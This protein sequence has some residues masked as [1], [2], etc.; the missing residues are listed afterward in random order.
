M[1]VSTNRLHAPDDWLNPCMNAHS[2]TGGLASH[3]FILRPC[4]PPCVEIKVR[5]CPACAYLPLPPPPTTHNGF[6]GALLQTPL[7]P[8]K[9]SLSRYQVPPVICCQHV[10]HSDYATR[11]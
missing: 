9:L 3:M 7:Q 5:W 2:L 4:W 10:P 1:R 6:F 11:W 8:N